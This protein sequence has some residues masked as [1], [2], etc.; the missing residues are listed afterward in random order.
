MLQASHPPG[1]ISKHG[2]GNGMLPWLHEIAVSVWF[3]LELKTEGRMPSFLSGVATTPQ[4][5][6]RANDTALLE[7]CSP[8]QCD[9]ARMTLGCVGWLYHE[10]V[11]DA[12]SAIIQLAARRWMQRGGTSSHALRGVR[13]NDTLVHSRCKEGDTALLHALYGPLPARSVPCSCP[14]KLAFFGNLQGLRHSN[15]SGASSRVPPSGNK[16]HGWHT[17]NRLCPHDAAPTG[18]DR[19]LDF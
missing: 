18:D 9:S 16:A 5:A 17:R 19:V 14:P 6:L 3:G 11:L 10:P 1:E 8:S 13:A 4:P 15:G 2:F 12:I 7:M